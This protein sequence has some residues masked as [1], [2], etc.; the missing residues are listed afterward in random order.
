MMDDTTLPADLDERGLTRFDDLNSRN[1]LVYAP[2]V[3]EYISDDN[4]FQVS[5]ETR[6]HPI[7]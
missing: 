3:P 5:T 7:T 4:G 2:T 6:Y 1:L